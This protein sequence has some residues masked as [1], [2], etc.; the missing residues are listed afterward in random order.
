VRATVRWA[1]TDA[2]GIGSYRLW[3]RTG[4]GAWHLVSLP[5]RAARS[6]TLQLASGH[7]YTFRVMAIDLAGNRSHRVAGAPKTVRIR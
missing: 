7:R 6:V 1:A 4:R 3:M 2:G 5:T